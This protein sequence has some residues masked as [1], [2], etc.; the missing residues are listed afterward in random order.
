[1]LGQ[2]F[3]AAAAAALGEPARGGGR[4]GCSTGWWP[5]RCSARDDDPR[6]PERGQYVFLQ[7]LLR[8]VAY[9]TLAR[10][11]RK[12]RHV[13][14]AAA[15]GGSWPGELRRHRRGAGRALPGGDPRRSRGRGRRR[16]ARVR[17]RDADRRRPGRRL[18]GARARRRRATSSRRP[19]SPTSELERAELLE[20]AGQALWRSGD[21][22]GAERRLREAIDLYRRIGRSVRQFGHGHPRPGWRSRRAVARRRGRCWSPFAS[23]GPGRIDSRARRG[24]G[25]AGRALDD[26]GR[27]PEQAQP[28]LEEALRELEAQQAWPAL[29]DTLITRGVFLIQERR[30]RRA[31]GSCV[32][33]CC[34]ADEHDLSTPAMR[35]R[36]NMA[37]IA[38][39]ADR[40]REAAQ[41]GRR[42]AGARARARRPR[43][44][45]PAAQPARALPGDAR[46]VGR[47]GPAGGDPARARRCARRHLRRRVPD[48]G[49]RRPGRLPT[50][51]SAAGP[52]RLAH[53]DSTNTDLAFSAG[54]VL[55]RCALAADDPATRPRV[56]WPLLDEA[57]SGHEMITE[58]YGL[59]LE[60]RRGDRRR[61]RR[62]PRWRTTS[63]GSLPTGA[64]RSSVPLRS[65]SSPTGSPRCAAEQADAHEQEAIAL[66]RGVAPGRCWPARCW[67]E[68]LGGGPR[69][70]RRS[71][72]DLRRTRR[73]ALAGGARAGRAIA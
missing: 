65:G 71:P 41:R 37:A 61:G 49:G 35:A 66:L 3:T 5:S 33:R 50:R 45:E 14:A 8:T 70:D 18:A 55:A 47:G 39:E 44:R 1:M 27:S 7:A 26:R 16:P 73:H 54:L 63:T 9:G 57:P 68:P 56:G 32:R 38:L 11:T 31:S 2:S 17:A 62:S 6:S 43:Q 58:A 67:S 20:Q 22:D 59:C 19:S 42:G 40:L 53:R 28:L 15:P 48:P 29:A 24:P 23:R 25:R 13:A 51:S 72:R 36:F 46:A 30:T 12:A 60:A 21:S 34:I 4:G 69:G 52:W 10:R 64:R